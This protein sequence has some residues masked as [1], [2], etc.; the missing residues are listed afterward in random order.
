MDND[1]LS[2]FI[3]SEESTLLSQQEKL[4]RNWNSSNWNWSRN[5]FGRSFNGICSFEVTR[6]VPPFVFAQIF[7]FW[8]FSLEFWLFWVFLTQKNLFFFNQVY[9]LSH[10]KCGATWCGAGEAKKNIAFWHPMC[11]WL[12]VVESTVLSL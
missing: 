10:I 9:F 1:T 11:C 3:V 12:Y 8:L 7:D 2:F 4:F 5:E 6:L